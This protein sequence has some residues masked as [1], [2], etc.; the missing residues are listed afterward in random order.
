MYFDRGVSQLLVV[1]VTV[2]VV[3]GSVPLVALADTEPNDGQSEAE[4]LSIGVQES[5]TLTSGDEDWFSFSATRGQSLELTASRGTGV[6]GSYFIRIANDAGSTLASAFISPGETETFG[7]VVQ[8][9]GTYYVEVDGD[10]GGY[11]FTVNTV[12]N[13]AFEPNEGTTD[14]V[15]Y[16]VG[17]SQSGTL[18]ASDEDWFS[19][20][21]TRGQSLELTASRPSGETGSYFI[22]IANEAG[23]TLDSRFISPGETDA[24]GDIILVND[25]YYV[26]VDGDSGTYSFTVNTVSND[27]FEPNEGIA[28]AVPYTLGQ[29]QSG[30]LTLADEDW[31]SFDATRGQTLELSASRPSGETDSYFVRIANGA[32]STLDSRFIS[33]GETDTL[34]DIIE[35]NGTY[36]VEVDG[37]SGTYSYTLNTV[38][39]DA[40]E[41]NE[42]ISDSFTLFDNPRGPIEGTLTTA[43][44]DWFAVTAAAGESIN[45]TGSRPSANTGNYV[46]RIANG[47]G[48]TLDSEFISPGELSSIS[49]TV[50]T[51]GTY[52][53]EVD[54]DSGTYTAD[55]SVAGET[56]GLPNDRFET[57]ENFAEAVAVTPGIFNDLA[58]VDDDLDYFAIEADS[59]ER[60]DASVLFDNA[61]NNL[62]LQLFN[63]GQTLVAE[64]ATAANEESISFTAT[65]SGTH[66]LRVS[67]E[68]NAVGL[69]VLQASV[70]GSIDVT[71]GPGADSLGPGNTVTYDVVLTN[72]AT[73]VGSFD[74]TAETGNTSVV[75]LT[76]AS[77]VNGTE[78]VTVA[79]DGSSVTVNVTNASIVGGSTVVIAQVTAQGNLEGSTTV[80][81]NGTPVVRT[82]TD[83]EYPVS[84]SQGTSVT[85]VGGVD[86]TVGPGSEAF[87]VGDTTTYDVTVSRIDPDVGSFD[88]RLTSSNAG[89][90]SITGVTSPVG[91]ATTSVSQDGSSA[92][93]NVTGAGVTTASAVVARVSVSADGVGTATLN[94][95]G[96]PETAIRTSNGLVYPLGV[97]QGTDATVSTSVEL[98]VGPGSDTLQPTN[99]TTYNVTATNVLGDVGSFSFDVESSNTSV[100]TIT[101]VTVAGGTPAVTLA[102]DGSSASVSV[103][104]AAIAGGSS[105]VLAQVAVVADANGEATVNISGSPAVGTT[106]GVAYTVAGVSE[107]VVTVSTDTFPP[108][109]QNGIPGSSTGLRPNDL[110]GNGKLDD[111]TGD[112]RFTFQDVIEFVFALDNI[113]NANLSP[114]AVALLDQ[115]DSG[116][117]TFVDVIDLVFQL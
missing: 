96:A 14:A 25:T 46:L 33:P 77:A 117:V 26:E 112:G 73:D 48:S 3:L 15:A 72:A 100:L 21:A 79:P 44:E 16:T 32:G 54:G 50:Q 47:G 90:L 82:T 116:S 81:F 67:G 78:S 60:I 84:S 111:M 80:S 85:V 38:P 113:R 19:F 4:P 12:S 9:T 34:G 105:V 94:V 41:P 49:T 29:S 27:A 106:E 39:N 68:P 92:T 110:D 104:G 40:F 75:T 2:M 35:V 42:G 30:S 59:G 45:V 109:L 56:L 52:Y 55:V 22:R 18:T 7:E 20:D 61:D 76:G 13:D 107:T 17:Q 6:T 101:G 95:S 58:M 114:Q 88:L 8:T 53:I 24:L 43:D 103:T 89:V 1:A 64:S 102:P 57:N 93:V 98:A 31:F 99:T 115:D 86:V 37:D 74:F 91:T 70:V 63:P 108:E 62:T 10:S 69:Y 36:Y 71:L 65:Q 51:S 97:I 83:V 5:G 28:D 87:Q 23:S 66:Y 11:T